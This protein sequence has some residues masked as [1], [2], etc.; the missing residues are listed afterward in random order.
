MLLLRT[1][2]LDRVLGPAIA[3][4]LDLRKPPKLV[5]ATERAASSDRD[6]YDSVVEKFRLPRSE[7]DRVYADRV[8]RHFYPPDA[9]DRLTERWSRPVL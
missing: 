4:L 2:D 6:L 7:V 3:E 8:T 9:I 1:E 5:R